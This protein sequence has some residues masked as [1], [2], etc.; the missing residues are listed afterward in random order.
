[1]FLSR[2]LDGNGKDIQSSPVRHA[3]E[4]LASSRSLVTTVLG[5]VALVSRT[6]LLLAHAVANSDTMEASLSH[7]LIRVGRREQREDDETFTLLS[8]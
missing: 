4:L 6:G 7:G 2:V 1:V 3:V 8:V 5:D